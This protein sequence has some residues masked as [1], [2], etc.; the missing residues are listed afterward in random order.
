MVQGRDVTDV[1]V[2]DTRLF[3][4]VEMSEERLENLLATAAPKVFPG[5]D[6][7]EFKPAIRC[8]ESTRHPDGVLLAPET[9][10]WWVV[11]VETHKHDPI[12]HIEAQMRDLMG[13]FYGPEAFAYL[14]R[15][16]NFVSERYPVDQY[17]PSFLLI[18]D[19]LTH[20]ISD[21]AARMA[22]QVV[23]CSVFRASEVNQYALAISGQRP[24]ADGVALVPGIM[25]VLEEEDGLVLLR[26]VDRK[27]MP[28]LKSL[29]VLV[30]DTAYEYFSTS[31]G[32]GIVL[33]LTV[34][35]LYAELGEA[36]QYKHITSTG[37]LIAM[38]TSDEII[39]IAE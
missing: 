26:P 11:E 6:Y 39:T 23:E 32:A 17:E 33:P 2:V 35:E 8:G 16:K 18:V 25:F 20:E 31:D 27:K 14:K 28:A 13:G 19:S 34:L 3:L 24:H 10:Q 22:L 36:Q 37:S 5:F 15:H 38:P 1:V 21:V 12:G 7:F 4:P 30:G 9:D 29:D